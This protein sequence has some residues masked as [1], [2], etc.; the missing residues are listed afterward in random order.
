VDAWLDRIEPRVIT[1]WMAFE[2]LEPFGWPLI[3]VVVDWLRSIF[4]LLVSASSQAQFGRDKMPDIT[5]AGDAAPSEPDS[6]DSE[7]ADEPA[8]TDPLAAADAE[9][10]DAAD[11]PTSEDILRA[12]REQNQFRF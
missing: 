4:S 2:R 3:R 12:V 10:R 6:E 5:V 7:E 11:E 9:F 1:E 8:D